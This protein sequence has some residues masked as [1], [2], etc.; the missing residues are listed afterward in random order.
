MP[1]MSK[2][3][4]KKKKESGARRVRPLRLTLTT[5]SRI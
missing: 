4:P 1:K 5:P 2:K 3:M